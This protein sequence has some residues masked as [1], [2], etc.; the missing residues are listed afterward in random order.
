M[1]G[2]V[3][4]FR[5]F[6][7]VDVGPSSASQYQLTSGVPSNTLETSIKTFG[8]A[9]ATTFDP[10]TDDIDAIRGQETGYC[11]WNPLTRMSGTLF[12]GNLLFYGAGLNT[13]RV[14]GTISRSSGKW[15]YESPQS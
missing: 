13:P 2:Y 14:N 11:T 7:S 9:K 15:Y 10:F 1:S 6:R 8:G 4:V 3:G 5:F 12:D